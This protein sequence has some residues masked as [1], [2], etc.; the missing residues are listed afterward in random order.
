M[1]TSWKTRA[2]ARAGYGL[3]K[4]GN[5]SSAP[6][7]AISETRLCELVK[8]LS[9]QHELTLIALIGLSFLLRIPSNCLALRRQQAGVDLDSET[10]LARRAVVGLSG[11]KL[12]NELSGRKHMASGSRLGRVCIREEYARE[13]PELHIPQLLRPVC[14]L[15]PGIRQR[16][17]VGEPLFPGW[18]GKKV[19]SEFRAFARA[20]NGPRGVK[21]GTQSFRSRD[22]RVILEAGGSLSQLLRSGQWRSSAYQLY[23]DLGHEEARAR[24]SV[25]AEGSGD[26]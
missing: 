14:Q 23:L 16:A 9:L 5:R 7:P 25:I 13:P 17:A 21:L 3:A 2:V 4:A 24:A 22:A 12:V 20:R 11:A 1:D 15:W 19:M 8:S 6:R 26:E 10:C 18:A